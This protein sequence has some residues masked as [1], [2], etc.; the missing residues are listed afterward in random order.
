MKFFIMFIGLFAIIIYS[1]EPTFATDQTS[2]IIA[3]QQVGHILEDSPSCS[4]IAPQKSQ[5]ADL[6]LGSTLSMKDSQN[7]LKS[8]K[9]NMDMQHTYKELSGR[10]KG[11]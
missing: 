7:F 9:T 4:G 1:T 5:N 2:S 11:Y 8:S 10:V 3:N 6:P